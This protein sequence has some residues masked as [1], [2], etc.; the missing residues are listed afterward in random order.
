[1]GQIAEAPFL[2]DL[3][4]HGAVHDYSGTLAQ[5]DIARLDSVVGQLQGLKAKIVVMPKDFSTTDLDGITGSIPHLMAAGAIPAVV[6]IAVVVSTSVA[7]IG[8]AAELPT[9][10]RF[11]I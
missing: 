6:A 5:S 4:P 9:V 10:R 1:M 7:A 11:R 2:P 3:A 8:V